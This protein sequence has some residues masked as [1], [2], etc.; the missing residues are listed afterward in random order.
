MAL[1]II[2]FSTLQQS[3]VGKPP[4]LLLLFVKKFIHGV[5]LVIIGPVHGV[6]IIWPLIVCRDNAINNIHERTKVGKA[7]CL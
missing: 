6:V 1:V 4:T 3:S 2:V 5:K 7:K